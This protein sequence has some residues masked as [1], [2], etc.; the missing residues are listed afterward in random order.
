MSSDGAVPS[1]LR[2][3]PAK[4]AKLSAEHATVELEKPSATPE[5]GDKVE[6]VVG[7]GDTTVHLHEE[8]VAVRGGRVEAIWPVAA[9][10]RIK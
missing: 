8:I 2:L 1:P 9:R 4:P 5:V 10:G 3:P 7:Y 6:F